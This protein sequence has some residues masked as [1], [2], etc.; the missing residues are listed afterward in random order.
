MLLF[1]QTKLCGWGVEAGESINKEDFIVEYIGEGKAKL[2]VY[3]KERES[4]FLVIVL[5]LMHS[6]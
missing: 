1:L 5:T 2:I 4:G 3:E 6:D